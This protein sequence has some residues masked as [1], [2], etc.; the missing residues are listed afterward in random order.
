MLSC[1][2]RLGTTV[3]TIGLLAFVHRSLHGEQD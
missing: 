3:D 2:V 1:S